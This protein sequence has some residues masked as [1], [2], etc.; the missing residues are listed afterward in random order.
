MRGAALFFAGR[1]RQSS[2]ADAPDVVLA[3]VHR[4]DACWKV[5]AKFVLALVIHYV[6]LS[7][8]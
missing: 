5:R 1:A 2:P 6:K 8:P 7:A 3:D 4:N